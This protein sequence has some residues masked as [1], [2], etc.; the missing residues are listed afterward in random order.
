[1]TS[2][3]NMLGNHKGS[4]RVFLSG[5]LRVLQFI[6][7]GTTTAWRGFD[8][9]TPTD[10][11][12]WITDTYR[13]FC[14]PI[15]LIEDDKMILAKIWKQ[16]NHWNVWCSPAEPKQKPGQQSPSEGLE[17]H[18]GSGQP[19]V[20]TPRKLHHSISAAFGYGEKGESR[21]ERANKSTGLGMCVLD[22]KSELPLLPGARS[23]A[24]A[25]E[26]SW[27]ALVPARGGRTHARLAADVRLTVVSDCRHVWEFLFQRSHSC[28]FTARSEWGQESCAMGEKREGDC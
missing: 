3:D 16:K 28:V 7:V 8:P 11:G 17:N 24:G 26:H 13:H 23:R 2:R 12:G 20:Y 4:V 10:F 6:T 21:L 19:V 1:M 18:P 22:S 27:A 25:Q 14:Y 5:L 9:H 15:T